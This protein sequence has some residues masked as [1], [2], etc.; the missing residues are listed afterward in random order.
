MNESG[1]SVSEACANN[2]IGTKE[3]F[4]RSCNPDGT[5]KERSDTTTFSFNGSDNTVT[6]DNTHLQIGLAV[7]VVIILVLAVLVIKKSRQT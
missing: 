7:I 4:D 1:I 6:I 5:V 3:D 2:A